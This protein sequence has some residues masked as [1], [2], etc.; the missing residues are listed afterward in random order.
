MPRRPQPAPQRHGDWDQPYRGR[1]HGRWRYAPLLTV[2]VRAFLPSNPR[3]FGAAI[4]AWDDTFL[5]VINR[6][7]NDPDS[8]TNDWGR[9]GSPMSPYSIWNPEGRW[10][11]QYAPDSPWNPYA[12]R[13][14]RVF[15][16][17]EFRGYLTTNPDLRPRIDPDWLRSYLDLPRW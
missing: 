3:L 5:G 1:Y 12:T 14:P 6:D 9:F 10:G 11:S 16:G 4:V 7:P 8:V 17:H 13:P 15:D 2:I